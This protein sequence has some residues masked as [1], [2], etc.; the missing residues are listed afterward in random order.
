MQSYLLAGLPYRTGQVEIAYRCQAASENSLATVM[1]IRVSTWVT[2]QVQLHHHQHL[3]YAAFSGWQEQVLVQQQYDIIIE[4]W[5]N[6]WQQRLLWQAWTAWRVSKYTQTFC[7]Q[8]TA[9]ATIK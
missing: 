8:D 9:T 7:H 5:N 1:L 6:R 2:M 3:L 4:M